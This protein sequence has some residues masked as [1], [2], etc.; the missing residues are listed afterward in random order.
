[1]VQSDL[2]QYRI[3]YIGYFARIALQDGLCLTWYTS[4]SGE[5]V[6]ASI[7]D[8]R[9]SKRVDLETDIT[10]TTVSESAMTVP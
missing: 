1:M 9:N 2:A 4:D 8:Y 10:S 6:I 5:K 3:D 7:L